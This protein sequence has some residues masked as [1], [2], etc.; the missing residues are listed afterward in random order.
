MK[1]FIRNAIVFVLIAALLTGLVNFVYLRRKGSPCGTM[2]TI[3][4]DD[5]IIKEV[6]ENITLCNFGSS[7]GYYGFDYSEMPGTCF[8]FALPA[9]TLSY[10]YLIL[11]NY[12][13][14]ISPGA[15]IVLPISHFS[16]FGK[17]ETELND[18]ASKNNRYYSFL[19]KENIKQYDAKT[20]LLVSYLPA[21]TVEDPI[22]I[23]R[24]ILSGSKQENLWDDVTTKEDAEAHAEPRYRNFIESKKDKNGTRV[25]NQA[26]ID[27]LYDI[28]ALCREQGFCPVLVTTPLLSEYNDTVREK[29]P[30][31]YDDFY[32]I[33]DEI[34][35][36]TGVCYYDYSNDERFTGTYDLFFNTD[37]LNRAGAQKFTAILYDEVL[38]ELLP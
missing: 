27:A 11:K 20:N 37:H 21:L 2:G 38:R 31:F 22:A 24:Q 28:L 16:F 1:R 15:V 25:F 18:F 5:A 4:N 26:E 8:N 33:L 6:P 36:A 9:Q 29:D 23:V 35:V 19:E 34:T 32:G 17:D 3:K 13:S 12:Q 14:R 10:D 7:H 30:A